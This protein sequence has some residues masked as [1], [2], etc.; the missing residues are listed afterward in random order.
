MYL[1]I[2]I[3]LIAATVIY[4]VFPKFRKVR[5]KNTILTTFIIT[6]VATGAGVFLAL[7]FSNIEEKHKEKAN[8]VK[9]LSASRA[10]LEGNMQRVTEAKDYIRQINDSSYTFENYV[11]DY[12]IE[13]EFNLRNVI[14]NDIIIRNLSPE[15]LYF[16]TLWNDNAAYAFKQLIN[17]ISKGE[18]FYIEGLFIYLLHLDAIRKMIDL[19]EKYI[20]GKISHKDVQYEYLN[21]Q[22]EFTTLMKTL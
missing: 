20:Q 21:I 9:I 5:E 10:E 15:G 1:L 13:K 17:S 12:K 6:L 11:A 2:T 4:A 14:D 19:E 3:V 22:N 16:Y 18:M 8:A 7:Y